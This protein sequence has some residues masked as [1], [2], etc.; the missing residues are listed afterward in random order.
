MDR[1]AIRAGGKKVCK[2][3]RM[4]E[5]FWPIWP[6]YQELIMW[7]TLYCYIKKIFY[8]CLLLLLS[9]M[10][11]SEIT[12]YTVKHG[13]PPFTALRNTDKRMV[14]NHIKSVNEYWLQMFKEKN[15]NFWNCFSIMTFFPYVATNVY[16]W[17]LFFILRSAI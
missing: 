4:M 7:K 6:Y 15:C 11:H 3:Q 1:C 5:V 14:S 9:C 8:L 12:E 13:K 2:R 16:S 10:V 17:I